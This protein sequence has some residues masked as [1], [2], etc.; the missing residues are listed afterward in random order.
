MDINPPQKKPEPDLAPK[1]QAQTAPPALPEIRPENLEFIVMPSPGG[2]GHDSHKKKA[3]IGAPPPIPRAGSGGTDLPP[4]LPSE[5][6]PARGF[7]WKT[8]SIIC[9]A[10]AVL[11][12]GGYFAYLNFSK[13]TETP[14]EEANIFVPSAEENKKLDTDNDGLTDAE[15]GNRGTNPKV[16]DTD[17]DG[18]A[19]GDEIFVYGSNPLL[20]DT[21]SDTYP[22]GQ[23]PGAGYSPIVNSTEKA[24]AE[25]I[26]L[27][28]SRI[29]QYGLHEPTKTTLEAG[30]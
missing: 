4:P 13:K 12:V 8:V 14:E 6:A 24:G 7:P 18:L 2:A 30:K 9:A 28:T 20:T 16:A 5:P 29:S 23:E 19:D 1:P 22:D 21:D 26:Q 3:D 27:W 10:V 11:A 15:E 25:E 17:G